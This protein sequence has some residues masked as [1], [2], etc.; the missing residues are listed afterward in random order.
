MSELKAVIGS[1]LQSLAEDRNVLDNRFRLY[2]FQNFSNV[3]SRA[4]EQEG[5]LSSDSGR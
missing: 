1:S 5:W 3:F 4:A 2:R